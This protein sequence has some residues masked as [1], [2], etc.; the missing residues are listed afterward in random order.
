METSCSIFI[1]CSQK[2][3]SR[4]YIHINKIVLTYHNSII[5]SVGQPKPKSTN[6]M[7]DISLHVPLY[8]HTLGDPRGR[9]TKSKTAMPKDCAL[10][11][12]SRH[13]KH[14]MLLQHRQNYFDFH[15]NVNIL[16]HFLKPGE[17]TR[18]INVFQIT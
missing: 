1:I 8:A 13:F 10:L 9:C 2:Y 4:C 16:W 14:C 12:E 18:R 15:T 17:Y 5:Y 3:N 6:E 11:Y 7:S